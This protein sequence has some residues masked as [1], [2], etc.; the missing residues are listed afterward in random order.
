[1]E[2]LEEAANV[3][4]IDREILA[5][6]SLRVFLN[7]EL[8]DTEAEMFKIATRHGIESVREFDELLKGGKVKEEDIIDDFMEF[9]Y[10]EARR[11]ELLRVIE[12]LR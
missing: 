2:I 8:S 3:L 5:R 4:K 6:N 9:D 7:K 12:K 11:D 10:L 1:M